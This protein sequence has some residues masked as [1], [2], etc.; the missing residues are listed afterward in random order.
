MILGDFDTTR[1][2]SV[3]E[4]MVTI[5]FLLCTVLNM[6]VMLNLLISIISES[7]AQINSNAQNAAYR[8]MAALISE[9]SYLIPDSVKRSYS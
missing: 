1:F 8:E 7:F 4:V 9:N 5:F 6:I 3:A 2:G